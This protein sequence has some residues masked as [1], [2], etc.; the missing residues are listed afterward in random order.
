MR[1]NFTFEPRRRPAS[2]PAV[3]LDPFHL[4]GATVLAVWA[5][6]DDESYLG[7]ALMAAAAAAGGRVVNVTATLGEHGTPDPV[8][9][10]PARLASIRQR[11]LDHALGALGVTESI[12]LGFED[13]GLDAIDPQVGARRIMTVLEDVEP[14]VVV[15]FGADGVTGHPDHIAVGAWTELAVAARSPEPALLQTAVGRWLPSDLVTAMDKLGA[16][17]PGF[18]PEPGRAHDV[19]LALDEAAVD[20]KLAA[21]SAHGSQTEMYRSHLGD[22]EYRRLAAVEA[23]FPANARA[24]DLL[25][26]SAMAA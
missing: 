11:E 17:F 2:Q 22:A 5:H 4:S 20:T 24:W 13:G 9:M 6:P 7:G 10:P 12:V 14:D 18:A 25:T 23:Y 26:G 8:A 19:P 1:S 3:T 21:L 15:S 16:F